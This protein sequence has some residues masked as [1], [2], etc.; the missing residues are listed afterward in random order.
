MKMMS[1]KFYLSMFAVFILVCAA[2]IYMPA[3]VNAQVLGACGTPSENKPAE[4]GEATED[5][6]TSSHM[7]MP[8]EH[9][10]N[11]ELPA[12][13]GDETKMVKLSDYNGK[14]RVICFY[15]ADFTFV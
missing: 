15:P 5:A 12:V 8:G 7:P 14:W 1:K 4:E 2:Q 6:M 13:V 11:F 9:A 3:A 10:I